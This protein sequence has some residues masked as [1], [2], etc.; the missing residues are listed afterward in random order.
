MINLIK[1]KEKQ[2]E[3]LKLELYDLKSRVDSGL[4]LN[5]WY[6]KSDNT[7]FYKPTKIDGV[8]MLGIGVYLDVGELAY[9]DTEDMYS[10]TVLKVMGMIESAHTEMVQCV[11]RHNDKILNG[12]Q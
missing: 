12:Y 10:N 5:K 8:H 4:E 2:I 1:E 3:K 9:L 11:K 6:K 7:L